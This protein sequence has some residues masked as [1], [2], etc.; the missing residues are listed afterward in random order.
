MFKNTTH[1]HGLFLSPLAL[2]ESN[3]QQLYISCPRMNITDTIIDPM[4]EKNTLTHLYLLVRAISKSSV[5]KIHKNLSHLVSCHIY[6]RDRPVMFPPKA[7][8]DFRRTVR[9]LVH[10]EDY[11]MEEDVASSVWLHSA[12]RSLLSSELL[13]IWS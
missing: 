13:S 11:V 3:L 8:L 4:I 2:H 10:F 5:I 6:C 7:V 1:F 9:H 12:T